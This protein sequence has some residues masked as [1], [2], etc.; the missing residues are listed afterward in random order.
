MELSNS[1][2][3]FWAALKE[4]GISEADI[5][6]QKHP[7]VIGNTILQVV[8]SWHV[9]ASEAHALKFP[10]RK[11]DLKNSVYL[12]ISYSKPRDESP[13]RYQVHSFNLSLAGGIIWKYRSEKSL[14]GLDPA[15]QEEVLV[16]WY[17][18]SGGQLKYYPRAISCRYRSDAFELA[19]PRNVSLAEKTSRYWPEDW[20]KAGGRITLTAEEISRELDRLAHLLVDQQGQ[21]AL[22][23]AATSLR[24]LGQH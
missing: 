22:K 14:M 24:K 23:E 19:A 13:R 4:K 8:S 9:E 2:A 15:N 7:D 5:K 20:V 16:D 17:P 11:L 21:R 18:L 6:N 1:P 12:V 3:K 10:G